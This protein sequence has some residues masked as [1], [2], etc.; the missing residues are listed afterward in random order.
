MAAIGGGDKRVDEGRD[1]TIDAPSGAPSVDDTPE[2]GSRRSD[3]TSRAGSSPKRRHD[4]L[5]R[6]GILRSS[7]TA[8]KPMTSDFGRSLQF[9]DFKP[10]GGEDVLES[11]GE[12]EAC[13]QQVNLGS[14]HNAR[15]ESHVY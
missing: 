11:M 3:S 15:T 6:T 10:A 4:T 1:L 12:F 13:F 9:H 8:M 14:R 2:L 5:D 7:A